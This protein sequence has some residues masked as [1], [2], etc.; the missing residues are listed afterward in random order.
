MQAIRNR[1]KS[2]MPDITSKWIS[3]P[4]TC[5]CPAWSCYFLSLYT[6]SPWGPSSLRTEQL[7]SHCPVS[8]HSWKQACLK[9]RS[10]PKVNVHKPL[11]Y[12]APLEQSRTWW[13]EHREQNQ[14]QAPGSW[15]LLLSGQCV[16]HHLPRHSQSPRAQ[17]LPKASRNQM[18][19]DTKTREKP[20]TRGSSTILLT[21]SILTLAAEPSACNENLAQ[22][23]N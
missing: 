17:N 3:A 5:V 9:D 23:W 21:L 2:Q 7:T 22:F 20:K 1:I 15:L 19:G 14:A 11:T 6:N 10:A 16:V 4:I 8:F 12:L 13:N 18:S